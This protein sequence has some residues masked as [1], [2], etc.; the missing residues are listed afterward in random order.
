MSTI[1][2]KS[3]SGLLG[4]LGGLATLGGA[5]IPGAGWLT[6]L[7][8]AMGTANSM[9]NG[10]TGGGGGQQGG[11]SNILDA[12]TGMANTIGGGTITGK[13]TQLRGSETDAEL[14]N[15]WG[16]N[17]YASYIYGGANPWLR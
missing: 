7:G 5:L 15:M 2:A 9:M 16:Q 4:T 8:T 3:G 12:I 1:V 17:P 11:L 14:N 13:K 10:G 6:P